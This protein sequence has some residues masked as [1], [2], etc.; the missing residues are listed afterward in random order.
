VGALTL[1]ALRMTVIL[2]LISGATYSV[3]V[4]LRLSEIV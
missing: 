1:K 3:I 2:S 4:D